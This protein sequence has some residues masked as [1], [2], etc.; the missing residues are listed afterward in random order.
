MPRSGSRRLGLR[1]PT[2]RAH[3]SPA[4][5]HAQPYSFLHCLVALMQPSPH[6]WP[7]RQTLQHCA[8]VCA[9]A[10]G[11]GRA[12]KGLSASGRVFGRRWCGRSSTAMPLST[13]CVTETLLPS[14]R[15]GGD[16]IHAGPGSLRPRRQ[17][18]R[19]PYG[20]ELLLREAALCGQPDIFGCAGHESD[21]LSDAYEWS[22]A[23]LRRTGSW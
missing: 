22:V 3:E 12:L 4:A 7:L 21:S 16:T 23:T 9:V 20:P 1:D 10:M 13:A 14:P 19:G 17:R 11:T 5:E 15:C 8:S 18:Q 6:G 2:L